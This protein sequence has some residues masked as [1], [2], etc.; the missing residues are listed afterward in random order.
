M[1]TDTLVSLMGSLDKGVCARIAR[2]PPSE[3]DFV[4]T[5][6]YPFDPATGMRQ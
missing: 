5:K 2:K 3:P 4:G 1:Q 6:H